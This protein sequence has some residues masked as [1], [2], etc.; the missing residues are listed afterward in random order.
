MLREKVSGLLDIVLHNAIR[1]VEPSLVRSLVVAA[2]LAP[3]TAGPVH[4]VQGA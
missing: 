2:P 1:R 4:I 3:D